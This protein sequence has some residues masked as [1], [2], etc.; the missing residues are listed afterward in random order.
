MFLWVDETGCDSRRLMRNYGYGT[1][2]IPPRNYTLKIAGK[3]TL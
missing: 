1:I 2:G 3:D